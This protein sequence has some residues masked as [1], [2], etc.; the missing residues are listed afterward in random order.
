VT[1]APAHWHLAH[2]HLQRILFLSCRVLGLPFEVPR[3]AWNPRMIRAS[4]SR[5]RPG[6]AGV[7][8][9][10]K[11]GHVRFGCG[12]KARA[13]RVPPT[14]AD[15]KRSRR[16]SCKPLLH[17]FRRSSQHAAGYGG[18]PPAR[19]KPRAAHGFPGSHGPRSRYREEFTRT[20]TA[21]A[22]DKPGNDSESSAWIR[23]PGAG[24]LPRTTCF[25]LGVWRALATSAGE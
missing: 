6:L 22:R 20:L 3:P 24:G 11:P 7:D 14:P 15:R 4:T 25:R 23:R 16:E 13:Q 1:R 18:N 10:V 2:W 21:Y 12:W 5:V 17:P 19:R 9:R 8:C